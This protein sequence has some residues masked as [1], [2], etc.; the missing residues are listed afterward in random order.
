M[1][2]SETERKLFSP[3]PLFAEV[4]ATARPTARKKVRCPRYQL[5]SEMP[6]NHA[7]DAGG[8]LRIVTSRS[9]HARRG[10]ESQHAIVRFPALFPVSQLVSDSCPLTERMPES[11]HPLQIKQARTNFR[12]RTHGGIYRRFDS[13]HGFSG[14]DVGSPVG[15][16]RRAGDHLPGITGRWTQ[17][18]FR[19]HRR[20]PSYRL[21]TM[22]HQ[23]EQDPAH[24]LRSQVAPSACRI[25]RSS[26]VSSCGCRT[27]S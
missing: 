22:P 16:V 9:H 24:P 7:N 1:S 13:D 10:P 3:K 8:C 2:A 5:L 4:Y 26:T 12:P 17:R 6:Q 15:S 19:I 21:S 18:G 23:R 20:C 27:T 25:K 14:W 11:R